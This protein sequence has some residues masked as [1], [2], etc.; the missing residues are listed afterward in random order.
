[1]LATYV[2]DKLTPMPFEVARQA[3]RAGLREPPAFLEPRR[4]VLALCLAK[5]AL[6]TG[7]WQKIHNSNFGNIKA[8]E[9]YSGNYTCILLNEVID[10]RV[11]W[12]APH[13]EVIR[14]QGGSFTNTSDKR[15]P[16]PPGHPQTRMRAYA[17][18]TDGAGQYVDFLRARPKM[19]NALLT[20]DPHQ[21]VRALKAGGYFTADEAPYARAVASL[22][23]E[24]SFKLEGRSPDETRLP[25]DQWNAA[26]GMAALAMARAATDAVD[27]SRA[28]GLGE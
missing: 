16:I 25:E 5:S 1:M 14:L 17:G 3:L 7:R 10:G 2:E 6:E 24:F 19:W 20:G 12:F 11:R 8:G 27:Y 9:S 22:F 26:R 28:G 15:H 4:E 23:K 13:G 21:F 18:P